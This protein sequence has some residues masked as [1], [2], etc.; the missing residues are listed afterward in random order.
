[1]SYA[2]VMTYVDAE[3]TPEARIR[4]SASLAQ[5]FGATLIGLSAMGIKPPFV[6]E[7]VVIEEVTDA[8][9]KAMRAK[10]A[11][12]GSW[13]RSVAGFDP[14]KTE[15]RPVLDFPVDALMREARSADLVV[16][17]RA[18]GP[19]DAYVSLDP[20]A[21][22]LGVGRPVLVVP[23]G[24]NT[25]SAE[26]VVIGWKDTREARRA[27]RDALPLLCEAA[28]VIVVEIC[29]Q[30][31]EEAARERIGDVARYLARHDV[32][33][34]PGIVL[35]QDG[36]AAARLMRLAREE[37]ADLIV[38]GAYG[39]SRLGEWVFGGMTRELLID[40]PICCLVSH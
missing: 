17:G 32:R 10:L 25:L 14:K 33:G 40:C 20:G 23:D 9:I 24:V 27:V 22:I 21:A 15:W 34:G 7:G 37:G 19:G 35:R 3:G 18:K 13:F 12:K 28:G 29:Q 11:D 2:T 38:T 1:M 39:H 16:I 26:R 6:A 8:E 5:K 4:V 36:P 30:G 31:E